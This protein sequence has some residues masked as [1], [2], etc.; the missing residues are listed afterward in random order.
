MRR[1][2]GYTLVELAITV[3]IVGILAAIG[4]PTF[5]NMMPKYRLGN[6]VDTLANEIAMARMTAI[7]KSVDGEV[8]FDAAGDAY[9]LRRTVGGPEYART[10][11]GAYADLQGVT[12][13][14]GSAAPATLRLFA[15]GTADVP[16]L[17]QAVLVTMATRDGSVS[18][19]VVVWSTGRIKIE[20]LG[21][22]GWVAD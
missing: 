11:V 2:G 6:A 7:S 13:L 8:V 1:Q 10:T 5:V 14:D 18:K 19:R 12:Y 16:V 17:K 4:I 15:T 20:R 21:D 22:S 3:T 9:A